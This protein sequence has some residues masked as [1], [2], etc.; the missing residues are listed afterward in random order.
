[1]RRGAVPA[2]TAVLVAGP[3]VLAFASGGLFAPPRLAPA[4]GA[5]ARLRVA[6]L[7]PPPPILPRTAPARGRRGGGRPRGAPPCPPPPRSCRGRRRR[8]PRCSASPRSPAGP[9]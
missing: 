6:P 9:R 7:L 3:T 5:G 4:V 8:A 2:L 1:M